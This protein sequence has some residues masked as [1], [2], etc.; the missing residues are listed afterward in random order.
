[1]LH[2]GSVLAIWWNTTAFDVPWIR[3]Q[4]ARIAHHCGIPARSAEC[5]DDGQAVRLAGLT[6]LRVPRRHIRWRRT[7]PLRTHL[8]DIG[9]R[10]AFLVPEQT[11]NRA[12]FTEERERLR[13]IFP[14]ELVTETYVVD[15]L[16][17]APPAPGIGKGNATPVSSSES[18][19]NLRAATASRAF[20]VRPTSFGAPRLSR[21]PPGPA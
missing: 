20:A 6:G 9:S 2:P 16:M 10:S 11:A 18:S 21:R 5:P 3:D 4:H 12:F 8:A 17:A 7:V 14:D 19:H 13:A 15:L 1:M